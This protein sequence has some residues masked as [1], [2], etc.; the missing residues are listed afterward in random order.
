MFFDNLAVTSFL[1]WNA[2]LGSNKTSIDAPQVQSIQHCL[3]AINPDVCV[4]QDF[5]AA[6]FDGG[7][8]SNYFRIYDQDLIHDLFPDYNVHIYPLQE[9]GDDDITCISYCVLIKKDLL[10]IYVEPVEIG[11]TRNALEINVDSVKILVAYLEYADHITRYAQLRNILSH[12]VDIICGDMNTFFRDVRSEYF[13]SIS[14]MLNNWKQ[15]G[16]SICSKVVRKMHIPRRVLKQQGWLLL[17]RNQYSFPLPF[18]WHTFLNTPL[19][20]STSW[21][22]KIIF[23]K[24]VLDPDNVLARDPNI[25]VLSPIL[26][27]KFILNKEE[28]MGKA[29]DHGAIYFKI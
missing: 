13:G 19:L 9:R 8:L 11:N 28:I 17:S 3:N 4:L 29:S 16:L 21:I 25:F 26:F 27:T 12:P 18:F 15:I 1:I 14:K 23:S 22:W 5:L 7:H 10:N 2:G 6:Y 24:P 20:R